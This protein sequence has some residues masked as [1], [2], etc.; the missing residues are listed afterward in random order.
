MAPASQVGPFTYSSLLWASLA[1]WFFWDEWP[2]INI[3]IGAGLIMSAGMVILYSK[4]ST[5][6]A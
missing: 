5:S 4:K 6:A 1:G 3:F 2:T